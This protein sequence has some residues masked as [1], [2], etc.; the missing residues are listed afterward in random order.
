MSPDRSI[1][2]LVH[3]DARLTD[4]VERWDVT[5]LRQAILAWQHALNDLAVQ[6]VAFDLP[7]GLEWVALDIALLESGRVAVPLPS[8]FTAAQRAHALANSGAQALVTSPDSE[9]HDDGAGRRVIRNLLVELLPPSVA[10][11]LPEDTA[12]VT[13]TSG[14]T[15]APKGICLSAA[16]LL[17]TARSIV[18]ALHDVG[19]ERHLC[20]LP[21]TLL[22]ENTAGLFANLINGSEIHVP[23]LTSIGIRGSSDVNLTDFIEGIG[24]H[25]PHSLILVPALLL[26]LTA[27]SE[28]GLADFTHL[29]FVAVGGGRVAATLLERAATQLL[30][31]F[32]GYG[33]TECGSVVAMNTPAH[34][35]PGTVGRLLPHVRADVVDGELRVAHPRLCGVLG[36]ATAAN[37]AVATGDRVEIDSDGFVI[38]HGRIK[39]TYITAFGRN[40][41]PEWVESELLN[42]LTVAHAAVFG[43]GQISATAL[44]VARGDASDVDL[45]GAVDACNERLPDYARIGLWHRLTLEQVKQA[46]GLTANGRIRRAA[47]QEAFQH[48]ITEPAEGVL[49]H[50]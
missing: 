33:L 6:V 37:E 9:P 50:A 27:A 32:E 25:A 28:F 38:V 29:K 5:Q 18:S 20:V 42:E 48:L 19:V 35:R 26:G 30:P 11:Q 21:L 31:V 24:W 3:P 23:N 10:V 46:D 15:G 16:T 17:E 44:L 40:V 36:D 8:F 45:Q 13:Y 39:N 22:L 2:A 4:G 49:T 1:L 34:H 47:L 14:S 7:N 43:E 12:L 41:S